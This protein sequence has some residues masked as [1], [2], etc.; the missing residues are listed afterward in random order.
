MVKLCIYRIYQ[1]IIAAPILLVATLITAI[2]T[3][4]GSIMF[5]GNWWG[6]W[7]PH[8]WS[9]L[10]CMLSF[11]KV[12]VYGRENI[13]S[14]TSYVFVSNHQGA[15]DI[16]TIYGYLNHNFKWM[17]KQ[18]LR[19]IPFVGIACE[20]A[21]HIM[22]DRTNHSGI[23]RTM[24]DAKG[25]LKDGTSLVVFPEGS[26]SN[27]GFMQPFKKGAFLLASQFGLPIVPLTIDGSFNVLNKNR[28][29]PNYGTITLTIHKPIDVG[30]GTLNDL[31]TTT[32]KII[33]S[34]LNQ[35]K[36]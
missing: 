7:P 24:D 20:R 27:D 11:V 15:Y 5:G 31:M 2:I 28:M 8:I 26:R 18:S 34:D 30:S 1:L 22:V 32:H 9:R 10:F 3:S 14:R 13:S 35:Y 19:N 12:K 23:R 25:K 33:N 17:M 21:G 29:I 16:F 6:Y 36:I 4:A